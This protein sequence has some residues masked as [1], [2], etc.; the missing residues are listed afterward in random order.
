MILQTSERKLDAPDIL[1]DFC[2]NLL[3][4][5]CSNVLSIALEN[6]VYLWN[7]S[8]KSTAEL[9]N[10][11]EED[12]P[13]TSV[14]WCPD[15]SRLAIGLDNSLVQVWDTVGNKQVNNIICYFG[16]VFVLYIHHSEH[17]NNAFLVSIII[18]SEYKSLLHNQVNDS[19]P[20]KYCPLTILS[21]YCFK[22]EIV[23]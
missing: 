19:T 5:G 17:V 3:D 9:V 8:N 1:D 23:I 18:R 22:L 13:V 6:D 16:S 14:S 11:D 7:A 20:N 2:L 15:G 21:L 10:V 12:G 4:W